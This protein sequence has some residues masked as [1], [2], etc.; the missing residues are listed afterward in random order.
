MDK[1][2]VPVSGGVGVRG[3]VDDRSSFQHRCDDVRCCPCPVQAEGNHRGWLG[4]LMVH[5]AANGDLVGLGLLWCR[6]RHPHRLRRQYCSRDGARNDADCSKAR[7]D[8]GRLRNGPDG[9]GSYQR[10]K[11]SPACSVER[12]G[13]MSPPT[14][15]H[16]EK[17]QLLAYGSLLNTGTVRTGYFVPALYCNLKREKTRLYR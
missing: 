5:E 16:N 2:D 17:Q 9:G 14:A 15:S 3:D 12:V 6:H 4:P 13:P 10:L 11:R 1:Q 8:A 7:D